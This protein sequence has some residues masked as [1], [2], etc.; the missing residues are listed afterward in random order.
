MSGR[1]AF[2]Q[3]GYPFAA[4]AMWMLAKPENKKM[5]A[6]I[7]GSAALTSFLTGITEPIL[8]SFLFVAPLAFLFDAIMAGISFMIAYCLNVVVGQGFAAGFIDFAFFGILPQALGKA[9]GFY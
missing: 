7:L 1:F 5:V 9:T 6:G 8:F 2:M 3:Y 4:L